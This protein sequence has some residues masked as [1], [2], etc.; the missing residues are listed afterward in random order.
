MADVGTQLFSL[1]PVE[2]QVTD[3]ASDRAP[4]GGDEVIRTLRE[5]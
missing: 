5:C 3:Y 1:R 4:P 2:H